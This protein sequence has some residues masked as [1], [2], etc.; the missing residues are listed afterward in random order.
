M[1]LYAEVDGELVTVQPGVTRAMC[2]DAKCRWPMIAKPGNGKNVA[3]WAHQPGSPCAKYPKNGEKGEWHREVQS[4]FKNRGAETEV[5]MSSADGLREHIAD[6]VL[7]DGRIVEAQT[8]YLSP[9][10]VKSREATYGDMCWL[11][12]P[13]DQRAFFLTQDNDP[14]RF[15]WG[16]VDRRFLTHAKP[17]FFD[18]REDGVWKLIRLTLQHKKGNKGRATYDGLRRKVADNL[19]EFVE[20]ATAGKPFG[21]PAE[22]PPIDPRK[23]NRG[24]RL[25]SIPPKQK[26]LEDNP[27]CFYEPKVTSE[28][29]TVAPPVPAMERRFSPIAQVDPPLANVVQVRRPGITPVVSATDEAMRARIAEYEGR[30]VVV[31]QVDEVARRC[32]E[33]NA[34]FHPAPDEATDEEVER[35]VRLI[36]S[37]LPGATEVAK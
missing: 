33:V 34:L 35:F 22:M 17:I 18:C 6:V 20:L 5:H 30:R 8:K 13:P 10:D 1:A 16:K 31:K 29:S 4:L 37:C 26:W 15:K 21:V 2:H 11:Y 24:T 9:E 25:K 32:T 3:H 23:S 36:K 28:T 27:T 12:D 19:L 14:A 7:A